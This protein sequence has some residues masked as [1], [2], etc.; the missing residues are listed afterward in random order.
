ML[1]I[2]NIPEASCQPHMLDHA[3]KNLLSRSGSLEGVVDHL[4]EVDP[5]GPPPNSSVENEYFHK[6]R[7]QEET[8]RS[9]EGSERLEGQAVRYIGFCEANA[10][11]VEDGRSKLHRQEPERKLSLVEIDLRRRI[12][13][14]RTALDGLRKAMA[15]ARRVLAKAKAKQF[16]F[17]KPREKLIYPDRF[18]DAPGPKESVQS[19]P[20]PG[21]DGIIDMGPQS[22]GSRGPGLPPTFNPPRPW[23]THDG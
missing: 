15:E 1:T 13:E 18:P 7:L 16:P 3:A 20:R 14:F 11:V 9:L 23:R 17:G 22:R 6:E 12:Y 8:E 10:G 5:N 19:I 21:A 2:D 4:T